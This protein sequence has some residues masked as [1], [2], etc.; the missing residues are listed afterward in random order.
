MGWFKQRSGSRPKKRKKTKAPR[1]EAAPPEAPEVPSLVVAVRQEGQ[2]VVLFQNPPSSFRARLVVLCEQTVTLRLYEVPDPLPGPGQ[3][4]CVQY[5]H[6]GGIAVFLA[7]A[8][9]LDEDDEGIFLTV[10]RPSQA[11]GLDGRR[12]FRIPVAQDEDVRWNI[13]TEGGQLVSGSV[14]D[15]SRLG[16]HVV[17]PRAPRR[18]EPPQVAVG[19]EV[20]LQLELHHASMDQPLR[21]AVAARVVRRSEQGW[22]VAFD[23]PAEDAAHPDLSRLVSEVERRMLRRQRSTRPTF[24][25]VK[26]A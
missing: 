26:R 24:S 8:V 11:V 14:A 3:V 6:E 22:G 2:A 18:A 9:A 23:C 15:I 16:A 5:F 17:S 7:P 13:R 21:A 4:C 19:S 1:A 10:Q 25:Q 12:A 20:T